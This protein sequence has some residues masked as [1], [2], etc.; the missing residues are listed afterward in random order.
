MVTSLALWDPP[1]WPVCALRVRGATRFPSCHPRTPRPSWGVW[2]AE[3][4]PSNA[5]RHGSSPHVGMVAALFTAVSC[6]SSC[7]PPEH[8]VAHQKARLF[9]G[10][11]RASPSSRPSTGSDSLRSGGSVCGV[12]QT[13]IRRRRRDAPL[14]FMRAGLIHN[15]GLHNA[16]S[17]V[18]VRLVLSAPGLSLGSNVLRSFL[19]CRRVLR[20]GRSEGASQVVRSWTPWRSRSKTSAIWSC[21]R[22]LKATRRSWSPRAIV[23]TPYFLSMWTR[24]SSALT[25]FSLTHMK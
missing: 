10:H 7:N 14:D 20:S 23:P 6:S 17:P 12:I 9:P 18:E 13:S 22:Q 3:S 19:L 1:S 11:P 5:A 4:S 15:N 2:R 8:A 21:S 25:D 24:R 16:M